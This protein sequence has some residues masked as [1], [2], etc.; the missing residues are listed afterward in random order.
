MPVLCFHTLLCE[1]DIQMSAASLEMTI[2]LRLYAYADE[3]AILTANLWAT[4]LFLAAL[5]SRFAA[6]A[7]LKV[8]AVKSL[9]VPQ[10]PA[11][12]LLATSQRLCSLCVE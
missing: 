4:V 3:L 9:V 12:D 10:W 11:P 7:Y 8:K 6:A 5:L 1:I 2:K